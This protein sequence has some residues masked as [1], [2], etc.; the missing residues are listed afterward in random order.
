MDEKQPTVKAQDTN[1]SNTKKQIPLRVSKEL[2]DA[3][4]QWADDE[5]RSIN[6]Q[7]EYVLREAVRNRK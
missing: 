5:F 6:A 4:A 7:I 2:Y 1:K 3:L